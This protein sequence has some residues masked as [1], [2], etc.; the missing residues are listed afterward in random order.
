MAPRAPKDPRLARAGVSGYN[1]PKRTPNHPTKSHVVV[2]KEGDK[3]KTIRFGQQGV[4]GSPKREGESKA[5]AARRKSFKA[6]HAKNIA[7]GKMS[8][9][10]WASRTKW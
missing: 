9:A 7:K 4:S 6:R 1:K 10:Y 2:A 8:A 5:S 3:V